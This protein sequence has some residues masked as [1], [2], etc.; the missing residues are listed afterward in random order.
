MVEETTDSIGRHTADQGLRSAS[1]LG[2]LFTQLFTATND[3]ILRWLVI[4]IGKD[5]VDAA[6]V[7]GIL[8]AGT[9]CFVLPYLLLAARA[10]YLADRFSKSRVI[11]VCHEIVIVGLAALAIGL[12]RIELLFLSVALMGKKAALFSPAKL[13]IIP[14][15]LR[16]DRISAANGVFG[17]A[18]V[19]ATVIGMGVGTWLRDATGYRGTEAL[20][21]SATVLLLV[22]LVGFGVSLTIRPVLTADPG[23][24]AP[25]LECPALHLSGVAGPWRPTG[26]C[27]ESPW[28][29]PSSGRFSHWRN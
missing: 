5:Y 19:S 9:A 17:L 20:W 12:E 7:G 18:T 2:L 8:A 29:S 14:E 25:S 16:V 27:C 23:E 4:G 22:A 26:L 11:V 21:L 13:G 28:G 1:F 6:N 15:L 10:G 24:A 3:N